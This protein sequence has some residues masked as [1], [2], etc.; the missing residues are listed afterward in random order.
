MMLR[1]P[2]GLPLMLMKLLQK[3]RTYGIG[4]RRKVDV[5]ALV[6]PRTYMRMERMRCYI[7]R[8]SLQQLDCIV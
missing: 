6:A 8:H 1:S 3:L 7:V 4:S 5:V 2:R